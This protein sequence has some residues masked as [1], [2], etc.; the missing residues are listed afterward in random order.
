MLNMMVCL[1][2]YKSFFEQVCSGVRCSFWW[3]YFVY[4]LRSFVNNLLFTVLHYD[5]EQI[6]EVTEV[7]CICIATVHG[8]HHQL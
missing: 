4:T 1:A 6:N 2:V 7:A 8:N 3:W 5:L